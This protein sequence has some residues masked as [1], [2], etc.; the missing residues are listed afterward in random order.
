MVKVNIKSALIISVF[1]FLLIS[2]GSGKSSIPRADKGILDLS[3]YNF[4]TEGSIPLDGEWVFCWNELLKPSEICRSSVE[5][6]TVPGSWKTIGNEERSSDG[7]G[8][9]SL[10]IYKDKTPFP[11]AL[12]IPSISSAYKLW[13]NDQLIC[14]NGTVTDSIGSAVPVWLPRV[15]QLPETEGGT[16]QLT[17]QIAN[18]HD[19]RDG[20]WGKIMLGS[21]DDIGRMRDKSIGFELFL[22]GALFIM[23]LYHFSLFLLRREDKTL[24]Y[25]AAICLLL[26]LRIVTG[27]E[28]YVTL[29]TGIPS[30]IVYKT[31]FLSFYLTVPVILLYFIYLYPDEMWS[32]FRIVATVLSVITILLLFMPLKL[33]FGA[34][35]FFE[36]IFLF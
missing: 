15:V 2:C 12:K 28:C 30:L 27:G 29:L 21:S 22:F 32:R 4:K 16:I 13:M 19:L 23:A 7:Y 17:L 26:S 31:L 6:Y 11:L 20:F 18:F 14:E 9:L 8:T 5:Y 1:A 3:Q 33:V 25:F 36:I 34:L 35:I 24:I 10:M